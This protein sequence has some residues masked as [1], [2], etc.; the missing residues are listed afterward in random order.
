LDDRVHVLLALPSVVPFGCL[1][2]SR[3][4]ATEPVLWVLSFSPLNPFR[5]SLASPF[6]EGI[7]DAVV[8]LQEA[9]R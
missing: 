5:R 7:E 8:D 3:C 6:E 1:A 2:P 4:Q 9:I